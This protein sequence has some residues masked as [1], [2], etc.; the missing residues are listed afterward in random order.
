MGDLIVCLIVGCFCGIPF[1]LWQN[2]VPAGFFMMFF[3]A[4]YISCNVKT[5]GRK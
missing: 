2:S 3:V 4:I 1:S 5:N